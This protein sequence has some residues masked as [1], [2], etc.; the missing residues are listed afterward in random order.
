MLQGGVKLVLD[1]YTRSKVEHVRLCCILSMLYLAE[2]THA[3]R[4]VAQERGMQ[5]LLSSCENESHIDLVTNSLKTLI[6]FASSDDYRPIIMMFMF[7][8]Y[9]YY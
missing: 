5:L 1:I 4:A 2:S 9:H 8:Y 3:Q 7:Y 6:P